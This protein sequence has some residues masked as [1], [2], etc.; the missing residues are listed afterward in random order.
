MSATEPA[1][2]DIYWGEGETFT[3]MT[4]ISVA[5][6]GLMGCGVEETPG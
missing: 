2:F 3:P 5:P 4:K 1:L 6:M